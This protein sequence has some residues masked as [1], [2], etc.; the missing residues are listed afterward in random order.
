[1][2]LDDWRKACMQHV[3]GEAIEAL[4]KKHNATLC[5]LQRNT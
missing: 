1:M 2:F 4:Q 5:R 3:E